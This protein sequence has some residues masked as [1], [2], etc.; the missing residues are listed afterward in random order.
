MRN[1]PR[2]APGTFR[3]QEPFGASEPVIAFWAVGR[4]LLGL[5]GRDNMLR[6]PGE[7]QKISRLL[8]NDGT[9]WW[10]H[11][12][13]VRKRHHHSVK[14]GLHRLQGCAES[15]AVAL[16]EHR[17]QE[18]QCHA[19]P[20]LGTQVP[21]WRASQQSCAQELKQQIEWSVL[22]HRGLTCVGGL[23]LL[24][25]TL[26]KSGRAWGLLPFLS[27]LV[28]L[29]KGARGFGLPWMQAVEAVAKRLAILTPPPGLVASGLRACDP[30]L[31]A[32]GG[33]A[34]AVEAVRLQGSTM[35]LPGL[36]RTL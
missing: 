12:F 6:V 16:C 26:G 15:G 19:Y 32:I 13:G 27:G 28:C 33:Q 24:V 14:M 4:L 2:L 5:T 29:G 8:R 1:P 25:Q 23:G 3:L 10:R 22:G 20:V 11:R 7:H 34:D 9:P 31:A 36:C 17:Q 30:A 18:G 21:L 35:G